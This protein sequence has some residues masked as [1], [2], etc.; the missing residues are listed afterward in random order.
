MV[1]V[2][3]ELS[4][5]E[6]SRPHVEAARPEHPSLLDPTH[7]VDALFGVVNVPSVV[8]IDEDGVVVRPPEP[9]WP[10]SRE[11]LPPGMAET[12]PAV[13]PAPNAPPPPEGALE[14][15]AV[16]NT[17]QHRGTYADAVRDWVARGA[18]STYALSPAEVVARSRPRS[19]AASEAAAHVEL[20]DHLWRTGRRDLAIAHFRASHR[21]QPDNW[22]YKRQAWSLV[23]NE[24]VGGPIGRFVQ[25][26]V[27][28]EEADWP[29]DSDF[30]SDLAQLGE[31]EYYPK[32]L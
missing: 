6:V 23:S 25:G 2:S 24:R 28:G 15:G 13:G 7:R 5:P 3:L 27:A 1:T 19:T 32:T 30:R 29:F 4:G 26:P 10:R 18:E 21:L 31:G 22:T 20:A 14:Q 16:L 11:G 9:G 8:W 12:I 17:G